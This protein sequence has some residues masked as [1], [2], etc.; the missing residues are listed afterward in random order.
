MACHYPDVIKEFSNRRYDNRGQ[1][2]ASESPIYADGRDITNRNYRPVNRGQIQEQ[3]GTQR[4]L[5][6]LR[7]R[8]SDLHF[9]DEELID[10]Y[11]ARRDYHMMDQEI[12][13]PDEDDPTNAD[14]LRR[15]AYHTA[16]LE[17]F[18]AE[19]R[20]LHRRL[21]NATIQQSQANHRPW[22][23]TV[24]PNAVDRGSTVRPLKPILKNRE[25]P[26]RW[27]SL[28]LSGYHVPFTG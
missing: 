22:A 23:I 3:F 25:E 1:D 4:R 18:Y 7:R 24:N 21:S 14:F 13:L 6:P 15:Y 20:A 19:Y 27:R 17:R 16:Q 9:E 12:D 10:E 2:F 11:G 5:L 26:K 8:H 28:D